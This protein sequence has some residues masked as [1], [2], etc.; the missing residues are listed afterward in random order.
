MALPAPEIPP[1]GWLV[2]VEP[3]TDL[4]EVRRYCYMDGETRNVTVKKWRD[5]SLTDEYLA[6]TA[7]QLPP[8]PAKTDTIR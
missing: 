6:R 1:A 8:P 3:L 7:R 2:D 4:L 5:P